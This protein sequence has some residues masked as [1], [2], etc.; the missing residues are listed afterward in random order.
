MVAIAVPFI[1]RSDA[2]VPAVPETLCCGGMPGHLAFRSEADVLA[3]HIPE[4]EPEPCCGMPPGHP[5]VTVVARSYP[6]TL[7]RRSWPSENAGVM[8][9]FVIV[10]VVAIGLI[11]L[12][13]YKRKAN[14]QKELLRV[15]TLNELDK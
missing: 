3:K 14:K 7:E 11:T 6:A 4:P 2:P 8:V 12:Y 10:G 13:F 1:P 9:V 5:D 15:Q